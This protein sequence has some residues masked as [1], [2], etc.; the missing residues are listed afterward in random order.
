MKKQKERPGKRVI[1]MGTMFVCEMFVFD[2]IISQNKCCI[3][4]RFKAARVFAVQ[5]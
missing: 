3:S 5:K 2:K 4:Q 1:T